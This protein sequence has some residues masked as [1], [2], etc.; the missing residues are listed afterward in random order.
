MSTAKTRTVAIPRHL[1]VPDL[2]EQARAML[3]TLGTL[4]MRPGVNGYAAVW[5]VSAELPWATDLDA[6]ASR[7]TPGTVA[8]R[9]LIT[10]DLVEQVPDYP[11]RY[12]LTALGCALVLLW[13]VD[14]QQHISADQE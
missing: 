13:Q 14:D 6:V 4:T 11:L 9:A 8:L 12:R 10:Y 5:H 2:S 3:T 7:D 1:F